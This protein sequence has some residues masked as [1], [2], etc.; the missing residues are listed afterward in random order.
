M[1][2]RR[3]GALPAFLLVDPS[4]AYA[5][6]LNKQ[7]LS[8]SIFRLTT[9]PSVK[10][11]VIAKEYQRKVLLTSRFR[12]N[13]GIIFWFGLRSITLHFIRLFNDELLTIGK[14]Q[15]FEGFR[16]VA[17]WNYFWRISHLDS[18]ADCGYTTLLFNQFLQL[19]KGRSVFNLVQTIL[20]LWS[21]NV[22]KTQSNLTRIVICDI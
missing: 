14:S 4:S 12:W 21:S 6:A 11:L 8:A 5:N 13:L 10:T 19:S 18:L 17:S 7:E 2:C 1:T 3:Y 22:T 15:I 9:T 16:I 20:S